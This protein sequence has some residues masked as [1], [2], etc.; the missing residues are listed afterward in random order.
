MIKQLVSAGLLAVLLASCSHTTQQQASNDEIKRLQARVAKLEQIQTTVAQRVG[1]GALVRPDAIEFGDGHLLGNPQA[2]VAIIEFTDLHCPF[3]AKFHTEIWPELKADYV[4]TNK[5][6]FVGR[7]MPLL[8][9][10]PNAGYAAVT[11]RCAAQQDKYGAAKDKLFNN[12]AAF[13]NAFLASLMTELSLDSDKMNSCLKN[14]NVHNAVSASLN[15]G[16]ALGFNGTPVFVIGKKRGNTV[17][18][19]EIITGSG[20]VAEFSAVLNKFIAN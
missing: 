14:M 10:H 3:C 17:V 8:K 7:D 20:S 18:D 1:L 19:Y 2:E 11:L 5:V 9:L 15:Y 16:T 6:L 4:D 13:D 12:A